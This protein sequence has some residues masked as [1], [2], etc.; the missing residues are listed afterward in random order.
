MVSNILAFLL[1]VTPFD[2][3]KL[4]LSN[5][6]ICFK[7]TENA[8]PLSVYFL[9]RNPQSLQFSLVQSFSA[10]ALLTLWA[11]RLLAAEVRR[12]SWAW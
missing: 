1:R 3:V 6:R 12:L 7:L 8:L 5:R 10:S 9:L 2:F 4:S 11:R